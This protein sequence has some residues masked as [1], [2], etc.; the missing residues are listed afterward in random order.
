[1]IAKGGVISFVPDKPIGA[2][3]EFV[4][5]IRTTGFREKEECL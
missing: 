5:G 2:M 1:V 3:R 4:R